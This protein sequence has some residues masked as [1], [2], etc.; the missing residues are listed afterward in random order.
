[1]GWGILSLRSSALHLRHRELV[2][3][4][5]IGIA[6]A[7]NRKVVLTWTSYLTVDRPLLDILGRLLTD[8]GVRS[9]AGCRYG[10]LCLRNPRLILW[11]KNRQTKLAEISKPM[12]D[13]R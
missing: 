5:A 2:S 6:T 12:A 13:V 11:A 3:L 1:M 7:N 8:H 9:R 10:I 4:I